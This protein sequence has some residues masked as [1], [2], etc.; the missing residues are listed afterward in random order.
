MPATAPTRSAW[1]GLR[2]CQSSEPGRAKTF[3]VA[4]ILAAVIVCGSSL[5]YAADD[6]PSTW[7]CMKARQHRATFSSDRAAEDAAR[8]QGAT[9]ETMAKGKRCSREIGSLYIVT[10]CRGDGPAVEAVS[11]W[12]L[13]INRIWAAVATGGAVILLVK[14][15]SNRSLLPCYYIASVELSIKECRAY[16]ACE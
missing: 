1:A 12:L 15:C 11:T 16:G 8:A 14:S 13:G 9:S 6:K 4:G 10:K 7:F 5:A 3:L 2:G